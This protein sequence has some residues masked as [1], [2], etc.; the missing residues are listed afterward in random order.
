MPANVKLHPRLNDRSAGLWL[1]ARIFHVNPHTTSRK[2]SDPI[3]CLL[4][5]GST[6][7]LIPSLLDMFVFEQSLTP[8]VPIGQR[9]NKVPC[10]AATAHG[11]ARA[12]YA[13]VELSDEHGAV[14]STAKEWRQGIGVL[15]PIMSPDSIKQ[16]KQARIRASA[17]EQPRLLGLPED[18]SLGSHVIVGTNIL[19]M[20]GA[21]LTL[22]SHT[23]G[24]DC[25]LVLP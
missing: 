2:E 3:P 24:T 13:H 21:S 22:Q 18:D 11:T 17:K 10:N 16:V 1:W 20:K 23:R 12:Y 7:I 25:T 15:A 6:H 4:D 19:L 8:L 5:T 14:W 9:D